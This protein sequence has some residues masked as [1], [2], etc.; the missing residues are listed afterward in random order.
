M[1]MR[2]Y[3]QRKGWD[4]GELRA[5]ASHNRVHAEDCRTD[6]AGKVD[7][8]DLEL[9]LPSGLSS[10]QRAGLIRIA[11][12]CPVHRTLSAHASIV[13]RPQH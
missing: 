6:G 1:T 10:A 3:A 5:R 2:L 4:I 9:E 8:F 13:T 11:S 12:R 7:V